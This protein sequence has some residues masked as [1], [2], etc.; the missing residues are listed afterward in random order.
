MANDVDFRQFEPDIVDFHQWIP[1]VIAVKNPMQ[2]DAYVGNAI[3]GTN[4]TKTQLIGQIVSLSQERLQEIE[5][6]GNQKVQAISEL[7]A[8]FVG[9]ATIIIDTSDEIYE[10]LKR[11][12]IDRDTSLLRIGTSL[13]DVGILG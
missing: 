7:M 10:V 4:I 9:L 5:E 12:D 2:D 1:S 8:K 6:L 13:L 11:D 3:V